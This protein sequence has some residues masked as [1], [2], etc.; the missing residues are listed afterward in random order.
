MINS[1]IRSVRSK[2]PSDF[3]RIKSGTV[4]RY[5]TTFQSVEQRTV[6][7]VKPYIIQEDS[8]VSYKVVNQLD[9]EVWRQFV[10]LHP[11]GNVF[12]T[13]EM[14][15]VFAQTKGFRP[16]LWAVV[17]NNGEVVALF[18]PVQVTLKRLLRKLTTRAIGY[19]SVLCLPTEEGRQALELLLKT[20]VRKTKHECLFTELRNLSNLEDFQPTLQQSGFSYEPHL[21]YLIDISLSPEA[22]FENI[23]KRTRKN[24]R[25]GINRG[26]VIVHEV[27]ER[28]E[29]AI[30]YEL[31]RQTY[32]A[33][34]VPLQ[35]ISLFEAAF[36]LLLPKG[37]VRFTLAHDG[38]A[39]AAVSVELLYKDVVYGWY[40]GMDRAYSSHSPNELLMWNILEW[41]AQNGYRIYDFG[42]AGK[43][44]E[45]Y[46]VREFKAK[47]GGEL[48][49][50]GRNTYVHAPS[51][52]RL[53]KWGYEIVRQWFYD[54]I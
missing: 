6:K 49:C 36:D 10:D 7:R 11:Q 3:V 14:F 29:I 52:L 26:E 46:G 30:C 40:G 43:P 27:K 42:G 1:I 39:P 51:L 22:V 25:H 28:K 45:E 17:R 32:Q 54:R 38:Q 15:Q 2:K 4:R 23:G 50:Y 53:S 33:A 18:L 21:N 12:H 41:G 35:D 20:Y 48:V 47:F 16:T 37:M 8:L 9:E 24:I 13:P 5:E 34:Q 44:D 19:G 31:L